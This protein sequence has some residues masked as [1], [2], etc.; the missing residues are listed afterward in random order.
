MT[1]Q[2]LISKQDDLT[3]M[4][5]D[6]IGRVNN[7]R[8]YK[9]DVLFPLFEAIIN[10]IDAINDGPNSSKG[11]I[12]IHIKR[13]QKSIYQDDD[14]LR[15]D[16]AAN[17]FVVVDNGVGFNEKNFISFLTSD[18]RLKEDKGGKG[19][20][21]FMWLKA[22]SQ[23]H[24]E[25]SFGENNSFHTFSFDFLL[26]EKPIQNLNLKTIESSNFRTEVKLEHIRK[27]YKNEIPESSGKIALRILEHFL[28]F[29]LSEQCP[30]IDVVDD[31]E[32]SSTNLNDEFNNKI[33]PYIGHDSFTLKKQKFDITYLRLH[34][35]YKADHTIRLCAD[36]REVTTD[37]LSKLLPDLSGQKLY[38]E[39]SPE[40]FILIAY[41]SG[42]YLDRYINYERTDFDFPEPEE[43]QL[44]IDES[45]EI[46]KQELLE[47]VVERIRKQFEKS[48][49]VI[50]RDKMQRFEKFISSEKPIYRPLLKYA[51]DDLKEI[52]ANLPGERLDIEMHKLIHKL[53]I[54]VKEEG[55]RFFDPEIELVE[56]SPEY[57]EEYDKFLNKIEDLN[58]GK[59]TEYVMHRKTI[60]NLLEQSLRLQKDGKYLK[61]NR[62]HRLLYPLKTASDDNNFINHNLWIIDEK[63]TYH[64]YLASDLSF[65][66]MNHIESESKKRP[67]ILIYPT[68]LVDE[69]Y[70][71]NS[72]VIIEIKR[73]ERKDYSGTD[74]E[75]DPIQQVI[76]YIK[77]LKAGKV[78]DK[79]DIIIPVKDET[80]FYCYIIAAMTSKLKEIL[81]DKDYNQT[82]DADGY[83]YFHKQHRAYIEVIS[84]RKLLEDS[85]KRNR[86]LFEQLG[87]PT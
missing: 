85:K 48:L 27:K 53:E 8:L 37:P 70:P 6:V 15:E 16:N 23:V 4:K 73:P 40:E 44:K 63:L 56:E 72:I 54:E 13:D 46:S 69:S 57:D 5:S 26:N 18:S 21:R 82:I 62:I 14:P 19:I 61:E 81:E 1:L 68:A 10:S 66:Q 84:F 34:S 43:K 80:R 59:L 60:L 12:E 22:F 42:N 58:A 55:K 78:K 24:I 29:F 39:I 79:D 87:L 52:P 17:G 32:G 76:G 74:K 7:T 50:N 28:I 38:D 71:Y 33:K 31:N 41:I 35:A 75:K 67:D 2:E 30:K 11:Q 47:S 77:D 83:F 86:V 20:G 9:K 51:T 65:D 45:F 49:V 64:T 25:S 3:I 36:Q